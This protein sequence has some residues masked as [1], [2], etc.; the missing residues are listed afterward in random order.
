MNHNGFRLI[1]LALCSLLWISSSYAEDKP[2]EQAGEPKDGQYRL[3]GALLFVNW[4]GFQISS[5]PDPTTMTIGELFRKAHAFFQGSEFKGSINIQL[6]NGETYTVFDSKGNFEY[7]EFASLQYF[8]MEYT[9][10]SAKEVTIT[11]EITE[12]DT[13]IDDTVCTGSKSYHVRRG[14]ASSFEK[15][16]DVDILELVKL[17]ISSNGYH[18]LYSPYGATDMGE[19]IDE[20]YE[21]SQKFPAVTIPDFIKL[22]EDIGGIFLVGLTLEEI[23]EPSRPEDYK[24]VDDAWRITDPGLGGNELYG[25][26]Y[27]L[28]QAET[29]KVCDL[30]ES[31]GIACPEKLKDLELPVIQGPAFPLFDYSRAQSSRI[32]FSISSNVKYPISAYYNNRKEHTYVIF[33]N[34]WE[35][36]GESSLAFDDCLAKGNA[37]GFDLV[38]W[39]KG[40]EHRLSQCCI[41][42]DSDDGILLN[43]EGEV[44]KDQGSGLVEYHL[45]GVFDFECDEDPG[46]EYDPYG[47]FRISIG[48]RSINQNFKVWQAGAKDISLNLYSHYRQPFVIRFLE[49]KGFM[50]DVNNKITLHGLVQE[51]DNIGDDVIGNYDGQAYQASEL[52]ELT[53]LTFRQDYADVVTI[54]LQLRPVIED[55]EQPPVLIDYVLSGSFVFSCDNDG[56]LQ[57]Y[58]EPYGSFSIDIG[59][60]PANQ[61]Q[62]VWQWDR[63]DSGSHEIR[64]G[65]SYQQ[66]IEIN[67]KEVEDFVES[68]TT[69]DNKVILQ[70]KVLEEDGTQAG[71][72]AIGDYDRTSIDA[73]E[74]AEQKTYTFS[75]DSENRVIITLQI[76][77]KTSSTS[78]PTLL[79]R[80][81]YSE[82]EVEFARKLMAAI[83]PLSNEADKSSATDGRRREL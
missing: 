57:N 51:D 58:Y 9:G 21:F 25:Q 53:T 55:G 60:R 15:K 40:D 34:L 27:L 62:K 3:S 70:G 23:K 47:S 41:S 83:F 54:E 16:R 48:K 14:S 79:G 73:H 64:C 46:A 8:S 66:S 81:I 36:D 5:Y 17:F 24:R 67:F 56:W 78:K 63:K 19:V 13:S 38:D 52:S 20:L 37:L 69:V 68:G 39:S 1:A 75:P 42:C 30:L 12:D 22:V 71:D 18:K 35:T 76:S 44:I 49:S 59:G 2:K 65:T 10:P 74:L 77:K 33:S 4:D 11:C 82:S 29:F 32:D 6:P 26:L 61:D 72:D 28:P 31:L 43:K 45:A 50:D 7:F 80:K